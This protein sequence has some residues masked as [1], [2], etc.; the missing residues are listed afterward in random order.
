MRSLY[1][2]MGVGMLTWTHIRV[3]SPWRTPRIR[4]AANVPKNSSYKTEF[5]VKYSG[6][7]E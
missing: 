2:L 4:L 3:W 1:V 6:I 5:E 7:W